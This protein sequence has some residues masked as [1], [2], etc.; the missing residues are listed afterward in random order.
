MKE[1]KKTE[2]FLMWDD[3]D[4]IAVYNCKS[5]KQGGYHRCTHVI[6]INDFNN[7]YI[8]GYKTKEKVL[9]R[10][11]DEIMDF[12][13]ETRNV[14]K[15]GRV[16]L[17][18]LKKGDVFMFSCCYRLYKIT[19]RYS[20]GEQVYYELRPRAFYDIKRYVAIDALKILSNICNKRIERYILLSKKS[21]SEVKILPTLQKMILKGVSANTVGVYMAAQIFDGDTAF[22]RDDI[23]RLTEWSEEDIQKGLNELEEIGEVLV[24]HAYDSFCDCTM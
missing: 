13:V 8:S 17:N 24:D 12:K 21:N 4:L 14:Q 23:Q 11:Y 3:V 19:E 2:E 10:K 22:Y 15:N 1:M 6:T 18:S 5:S 20:F 7:K 16:I 9:F